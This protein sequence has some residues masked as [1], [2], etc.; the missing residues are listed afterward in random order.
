MAAADL[1]SKKRKSVDATT[2]AVKKVKTAPSAEKP[3]PVK[4]ALKKSKVETTKKSDGKTTKTATKATKK[5]NKPTKISA[6]KAIEPAS[7]DENEADAE[8]AANHELTAAQ[9]ANLLAGFSSSEDEADASDAEAEGI[10][11]AKLPKA[12]TAG[13]A[14][15]DLSLRD[16][17]DRIAELLHDPTGSAQLWPW[18]R[19][20]QV[21]YTF[22]REEDL[23]ALSKP[24]DV[25]SWRLEKLR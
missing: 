3:A 23:D 15:M 10:P 9:T 19:T 13:Q 12:P 7:D 24:R 18:I 17:M 25:F 16:R 14:Y 4:S 20:G 22:A 1:R 8:A 6:V 11:V 2:T 5:G 21:Y